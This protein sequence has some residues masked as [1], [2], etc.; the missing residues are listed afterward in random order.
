MVVSL[1]ASYHKEQEYIRFRGGG[2]GGSET[3]LK[4]SAFMT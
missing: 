2:G 3:F 4:Y 1:D